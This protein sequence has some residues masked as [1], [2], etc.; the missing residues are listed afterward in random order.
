MPDPTDLSH[1]PVEHRFD[2]LD[3]TDRA[4]PPTIVHEGAASRQGL[5]TERLARSSRSNVVRPPPRC[6]AGRR[7][8]ARIRISKKYK[9]APNGKDGVNRIYKR[10]ER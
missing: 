10:L 3:A 9:G 1:P 7:R 8:P 4:D 2:R 5:R 6:S